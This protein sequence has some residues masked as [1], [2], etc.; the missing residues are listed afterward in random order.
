MQGWK[1]PNFFSGR[2]IG[3]LGFDAKYPIY[4]NKIMVLFQ[5]L[6]FGTWQSTP[7]LVDIGPSTS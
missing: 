1:K 5:Y 6:A 4:A 2:C 3:F 7:P